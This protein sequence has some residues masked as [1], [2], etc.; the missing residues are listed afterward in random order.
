MENRQILI[1]VENI[2]PTGGTALTPFWVGLHNGNFDTLDQGRPASQG[3]E[4]IAEDGN[5]EVLN[6]EFEQSGFGSVQGVVAGPQGPLLPGES[7]E[8]LLDVSDPTAARY[9]NY[10]A[11]VLPSNDFFVANDEQREH[12]IFDRK[13]RFVG[14]DFIVAGE[15]VLDAGTEVSDEIP[16]NTAFFG[17]QV[18]DTG[19]EENGVIRPSE[20][21]IPG[22]NILSSPDFS[23]ADFTAAGYEIARVRVF[24]AIVGTDGADRLKGTRQDDYLAGKGS[25]DTIFA[26]WG[27]DRVVGDEGDDKL[28]GQGGDDELYGGEGDDLLKGG[29]GNDILDGGAGR[30]V[31][32]GGSGDDIFVLS[33]DG[34]ADILRFDSGDRLSL[35]SSLQFSEL[36]FSQERRDTLISAGN[37]QIARLHRVDA[38][39]ITEATFV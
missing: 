8:L 15:E 14:A 38:S 16:Q 26:G 7:G 33:A 20:G 30:N 13:G 12:E 34:F 17:Q 32:H 31:L 28:F 27:N 37:E 9:L 23:N 36:Q 25:N 11:M 1:S 5:V 19:V 3:V 24:N 4:R 10:A 18:P 6:Q 22:G 21:F 29:R 2:A 39:T 35:G